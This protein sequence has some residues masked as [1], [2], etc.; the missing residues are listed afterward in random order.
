MC[1]SIVLYPPFLREKSYVCGRQG[2]LSL[3]TSRNF[4]AVS[5]GRIAPSFE[6]I[7][8]RTFNN[9]MLC[10]VRVK[11]FCLPPRGFA[12]T[13]LAY[14]CDHAMALPDGSAAAEERHDKHGSA[15]GDAG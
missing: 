15:D 6:L 4:T 8:Y 13:T 5:D 3:A 10:N 7:E 9:Y 11:Y 2:P 12:K 14:H 1:T